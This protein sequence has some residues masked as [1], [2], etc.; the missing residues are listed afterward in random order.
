MSEM[1]RLNLLS[2]IAL[3]FALG[4]FSKV[5]KSEFSIPKDLYQSLAIYLLLAIGIK[6]GVELSHTSVGEFLWPAAVTVLLGIITPVSSYLVLRKVGR[7]ST[8][9]SAGIAAH[10]GSVSAVT[11]IAAQQFVSALGSPAEGFMPRTE[12]TDSSDVQLP[13][14]SQPQSSGNATTFRASPRLRSTTA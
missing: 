3:A 4:L 5:I 6:G 12:A 10:Y 1:L 9:D 7:F 11:F 8:A 14:S 13:R 2:P